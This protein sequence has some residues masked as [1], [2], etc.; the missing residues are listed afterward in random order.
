MKLKWKDIRTILIGLLIAVAGWEAHT[1]IREWFSHI[2]SP[3][4]QNVYAQS[5]A[6][7]LLIIILIAILMKESPLKALKQ[8]FK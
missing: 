2:T 6:T 4:F 8:V 7:I 5:M 1:I 3:F